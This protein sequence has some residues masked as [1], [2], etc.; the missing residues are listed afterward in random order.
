MFFHHDSRRVRI[1][2]ITS[3]PVAN[4][5]TQQACNLS[6]DL[7]DR[8]NAVKFL[9]RDRDTKYTASFDATFAADAIRVI[10]TRSGPLGPTPSANA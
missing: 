8:A 10:R 2:G 6:M 7:A 3:N 4:C 1:A 9:I 5:F